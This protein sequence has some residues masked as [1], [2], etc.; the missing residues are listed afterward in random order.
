MGKLHL[1]SLRALALSFAMVMAA[2]AFAASADEDCGDDSPAVQVT[3]GWI[4][5]KA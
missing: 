1:F 2:P 4:G 3:S 5:V